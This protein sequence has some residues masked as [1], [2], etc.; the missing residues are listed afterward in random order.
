MSKERFSEEKLVK[1]KVNFEV[2][3]ESLE[4]IKRE[5]KLIDSGVVA[6][7]EELRDTGFVKHNDRPV[8]EQILVSKNI[9]GKPKYETKVISEYKPA[10]IK[11]DIK[12]EISILFNG[13]PLGCSKINIE[14]KDDLSMVLA[15]E[16]RVGFNKKSRE[17]VKIDEGKL[18]EVI[19]EEID[20]CNNE[21]TQR[22]ESYNR[23][24]SNWENTK[25]ELAEMYPT[26]FGN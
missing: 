12:G 26:A 22:R 19:A 16:V 14:V 18:G 13:T 6:L 3:K 9:F 25:K 7:F 20:R 10:Q 8:T 17:E 1:D 11:K 2:I 23:S 24:F 21:A 4:D 15:R 5:K